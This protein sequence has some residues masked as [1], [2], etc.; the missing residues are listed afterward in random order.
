[1]SDNES[2][3][4]RRERE[5]AERRSERLEQ[6]AENRD[7]NMDADDANVQRMIERSI[8]DHGA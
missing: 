6:V 4:K 3:R 8:K 1:M 7:A 5:S 2:G